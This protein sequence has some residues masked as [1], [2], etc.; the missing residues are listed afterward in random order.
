[1]QCS[2]IDDISIIDLVCADRSI[3]NRS[4][5]SRAFIDDFSIRYSY[6]SPKATPHHIV[7]HRP[8]D[9]ALSSVVLSRSRSIYRLSIDIDCLSIVRYFVVLIGCACD[10]RAL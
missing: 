5:A 4:L 2:L 9:R 7:A 3:E 6:I 1:M 8:M 10:R